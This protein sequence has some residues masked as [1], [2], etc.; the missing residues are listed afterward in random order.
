M[1]LASR[2]KFLKKIAG[3]Y[4]TGMYQ[5]PET[6]YNILTED[7]IFRALKNVPNVMLM[8][9]SVKVIMPSKWY[10]QKAVVYPWGPDITFQ[11]RGRTPPKGVDWLS[12][13]T[14]QGDNKLISGVR[15]ALETA[16]FAQYVSSVRI[17]YNDNNNYSCVI[18]MKD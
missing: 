3:K 15:H 6:G 9:G 7:D 16:P 11:F 8:P 18:T 2:I 13:Q 1:R 10:K 14:G 5:D 12:E 17:T 4:S